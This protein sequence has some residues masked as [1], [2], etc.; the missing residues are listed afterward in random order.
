[1]VLSAANGKNC[2]VTE[3][4]SYTVGFKSH[5]DTRT[6][7]HKHAHTHSVGVEHFTPTQIIQNIV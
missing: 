3:I 5:K 7:V 4:Y 2:S 1:M 6:R